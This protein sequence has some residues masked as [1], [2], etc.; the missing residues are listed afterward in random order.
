VAFPY[1]TLPYSSCFTS[2]PNCCTH[3][4]NTTHTSNTI[5]ILDERVI[6]HEA[7]IGSEGEHWKEAMEFEYV[8]LLKN[9]TTMD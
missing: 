6:V 1:T 8:S 7:S 4:A 9:Q 2:K 3:L 5:S